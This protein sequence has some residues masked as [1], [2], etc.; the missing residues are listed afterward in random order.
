MRETDIGGC[1]EFWTGEFG[2]RVEVD[3]VDDFADAVYDDLY[4]CKLESKSVISSIRYTR[5][6]EIYTISST[7]KPCARSEICS[8]GAILSPK[9]RLNNSKLEDIS[10]NLLLQRRKPPIIIP[11][12]GWTADPP[13]PS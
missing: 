2:E 6:P 5:A 4:Q 7:V 8:F 12:L 1:V 9:T 13:S 11:Q 3:V 10:E